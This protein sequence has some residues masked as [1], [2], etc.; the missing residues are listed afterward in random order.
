[1]PCTPP[2]DHLLHIILPA[3]LPGKLPLTAES[4]GYFQKIQIITLQIFFFVSA[5]IIG[6]SLLLPVGFLKCSQNVLS[7]VLLTISCGALGLYAPTG[8]TNPVDLSPRFASIVMSIANCGTNIPGIL[9][10]VVA[11]YLTNHQVRLV[12][13]FNLFGPWASRA[14]KLLY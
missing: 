8:A 2:L 11:G 7:I 3:K 12:L 4:I 14:D 1:M 6:A 13:I 9:S 10:P 5:L